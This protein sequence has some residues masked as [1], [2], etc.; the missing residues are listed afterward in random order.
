MLRSTAITTF[1]PTAF[2]QKRHEL[3]RTM[4]KTTQ[5]IPSKTPYNTALPSCLKDFQQSQISTACSCLSIPTP[6]TTSAS[7][8]HTTQTTTAITAVRHPH[9]CQ[10]DRLT[11]S[12][13]VSFHAGCNAHLHHNYNLN[14]H[15]HILPNTLSM[16]QPGHPMGAL[17]Q[18]RSK[19]RP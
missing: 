13:S 12:H 5:P 8:T 9:S 3:P 7:T 18:H 2:K 16:F 17:C 14:Q 19:R 6:R 11:L 1:I 15:N 4:T 10:P